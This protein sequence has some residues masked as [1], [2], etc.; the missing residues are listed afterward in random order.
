MDAHPKERRV[1]LGEGNYVKMVVAISHA[2]G[3][4]IQETYKHINSEYFA[5]FL[6][7]NFNIRV[8]SA[9]KDSWLWVQDGDPSQNSKVMESVDGQLFSIP[10]RN[11]DMNRIEIFGIV[12]RKL[13]EDAISQNIYVETIDEFETRIR[14]TIESLPYN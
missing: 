7:N 12:K 6:K 3:T 11:P 2:K 13:K 9:E 10:S 5:D 8:Q 4:V 14:R 1:E